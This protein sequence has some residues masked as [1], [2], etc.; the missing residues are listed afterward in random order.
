MRLPA[1]ERLLSKSLVKP[2]DLLLW[3]TLALLTLAMS[4]YSNIDWQVAEFYHGP[5]AGGFPLR[6]DAFWVGAHQ[7][8]R[9]LSTVLWAILLIFTVRQS[10][11]QTLRQ[12]NNDEFVR[13]GVFILLASAVALAVNGILKTNSVHSCPWSLTAFGGTADFFRLL[14]PIPANP[15]NGGCLPSGHAAVGFMWWPMVYACAR[16]RP[17]LTALAFALVL[18]FGAFCGY[19]QIVRG[20]HFVSHVL[21]TAAVTGA[22]SSLVFHF[23]MRLKFW[24]VQP[25]PVLCEEQP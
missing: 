13:A 3:L 5:Q 22:C 2:Y 24:R 17:S 16:W 23:C 11:Q 20:A 9:N 4:R 6:D 18:A 1:S 8:T 19:L 12:K 7:L 14:D 21:M 25:A 15:G 10:R